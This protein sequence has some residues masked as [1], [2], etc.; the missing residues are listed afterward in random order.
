MAIKPV[1]TRVFVLFLKSRGIIYIRSHA[2]HD[3]FDNPEKSIATTSS[4]KNEV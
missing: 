2:S 4:Y 3:I 1:P